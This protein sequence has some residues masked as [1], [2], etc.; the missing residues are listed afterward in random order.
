MAAALPH[1]YSVLGTPGQN[2]GH[3]VI[4]GL[5]LGSSTDDAVSAQRCGRSVAVDLEGAKEEASGRPRSSSGEAAS[6]GDPAR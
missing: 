4:A 2:L 1:S 6:V 3:S 5:A